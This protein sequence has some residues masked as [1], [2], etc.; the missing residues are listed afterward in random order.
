MRLDEIVRDF[1]SGAVIFGY[2][3]RDPE[4][5]GV[6]EFDESGK[7]VVAGREAQAAALEPGGARH[8]PVRR[9]RGRAHQAPAPVARAASSRSPT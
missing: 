5:Y 2:P 6:V 1:A 9:E 8:L 7:V 4:R 3:V